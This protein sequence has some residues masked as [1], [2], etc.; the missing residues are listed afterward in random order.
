MLPAPTLKAP[1]SLAAICSASTY[2]RVLHSHGSSYRDVVRAF[3]GR[4]DDVTDLVAHP[5]D[6]DEL[7]AVMDWAIDAGA[8]VIPF[9]GG[10]SVV[11]GV[12]PAV[13]RE[14]FKGVV[15]INLQ[16]L[17]RV[18]EVDKQSLAARIQAGASAPARAPARR[19]R[20]DAAPLPA[21]V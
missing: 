18:L 14:R 1:E 2:E 17:D 5:R 21:V 16:A 12:E 11:G 19:A 4:L 9:G 15:T 20:S 10:T 13:D 6:E 7:Q 3:Q 8:A